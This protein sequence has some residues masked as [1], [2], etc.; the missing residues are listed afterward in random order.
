VIVRKLVPVS[1][2]K[3]PHLQQYVTI[4]YVK[5]GAT[6]F[7]SK[8]ELRSSTCCNSDLRTA[9]NSDVIAKSVVG[10]A[11]RCLCAG[12]RDYDNKEVGCT[13]RKHTQYYITYRPCTKQQ[14]NNMLIL[15]VYTSIRIYQ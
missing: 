15:T 3:A 12:E 10:T 1:G 11:R 9:W 8:T 6:V 13:Q 7:I 5:F 2:W 4:S 14:L